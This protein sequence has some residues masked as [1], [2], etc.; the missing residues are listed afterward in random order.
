MSSNRRPRLLKI[1]CVGDSSV[2]K[3]SLMHLYCSRKVS[4]KPFEPTV[5]VDFLSH[6]TQVDER[7]CRLQVWDTAGQERFRS[8][9]SAYLRGASGI[10]IVF[11]VGNEQSFANVSDVWKPLLCNH[12]GI[13]SLKAETCAFVLVGNK[14]DAPN[15]SVSR[16]RAEALAAELAVPY[17]ETSACGANTT[18]LLRAVDDAFNSVVRTVVEE[19]EVRYEVMMLS[20]SSGR[21]FVRA[22]E[23]KPLQQCCTT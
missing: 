5:G 7:E 8:V 11:D 3:T 21:R 19:E 18:Q 9:S 16:E 14:C 10:V 17:Y 13:A 23:R 6:N 12:L 1:V 22:N 4:E 15:R 20:D 2:G